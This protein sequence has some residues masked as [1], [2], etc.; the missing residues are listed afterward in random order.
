[1]RR[2]AA[3]R[4][5]LGQQ[6]LL[7]NFRLAV[8]HL[9]RVIW[10]IAAINLWRTQLSK[11]MP[12]SS[13]AAQAAAGLGSQLLPSRFASSELRRGGPQGVSNS[14]GSGRK[15]YRQGVRKECWQGSREHWENK[16]NT[17]Q[18]G[19]FLEWWAKCN[20]WE[21]AMVSLSF[22]NLKLR[23]LQHQINLNTW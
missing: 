23:S 18:T 9:H 15:R 10:L 20:I 4:N 3:K 17:V 14:S 16:S 22:C 13:K 1:M 8:R 7:P 11:E 19:S 12:S 5:S 2:P 21:F 6:L